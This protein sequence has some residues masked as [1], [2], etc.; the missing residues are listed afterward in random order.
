MPPREIGLDRILSALE[1]QT[2]VL[3]GIH[4]ELRKLSSQP[5]AEV[6]REEIKGAFQHYMKPSGE[7]PVGSRYDPD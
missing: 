6:Q 3:K 7:V 1:E 4:D 2:R 5:S